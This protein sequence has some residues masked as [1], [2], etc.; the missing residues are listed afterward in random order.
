MASTLEQTTHDS[1]HVQ[2]LT[3]EEAR[4]LFDE[5]AR[6]YLGMSGDE[7]LRRWHAGDFDRDPD[8]P[9]IMRVAMLR[10]LVERSPRG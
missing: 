6:R 4:E 3:R 8:Q 7:F 2:E 10:Y 9:A 1:E 5:S